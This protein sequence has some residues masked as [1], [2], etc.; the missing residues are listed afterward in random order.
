M[1]VVDPRI[2]RS[3]GFSASTISRRM[4]S[5][6]Y[7][8]CF[9]RRAVWSRATT[10]TSS[11]PSLRASF[12]EVDVARV[13]EVEDP[14]GHYADDHARHASTIVRPSRNDQPCASA[15]ARAASGNAPRRSRRASRRRSRLRQTRHAGERDGEFRMTLPLG[16]EPRS[17][18]EER[19]VTRRAE[20]RGEPGAE[21]RRR[22]GDPRPGR[23]RR[24][25]GS[26]AP[27]R[28]RGSP[29]K[30]ARWLT[31]DAERRSAGRSAAR[32]RARRADDREV[33]LARVAS[34]SA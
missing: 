32:S 16:K 30:V 34:S 12:E 11:S 27:G 7:G 10:T 1:S 14:R 8:S 31:V 25:F 23:A 24:P 22:R 17:G 19:E 26:R 18:V 21:R 2:A 3:T 29:V 6:T 9:R 15:Y 4:C 33:A 5:G 28:C 20:L 13:E